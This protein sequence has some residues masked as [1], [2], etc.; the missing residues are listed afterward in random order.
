MADTQI[1]AYSDQY[2]FT[3]QDTNSYW[4]MI[5]PFPSV[6][7]TTS[8]FSNALNI[9]PHVSFTELIQRIQSSFQQQISPKLKA[10]TMQLNQQ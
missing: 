4:I 8:V 1:T 2:Y 10:I 7:V 5:L 3:V 9:K 6:Q